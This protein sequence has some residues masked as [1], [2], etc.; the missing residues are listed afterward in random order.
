MSCCYIFF[1]FFK[2][3]EWLKDIKRD[4]SHIQGKEELKILKTYVA[5]GNHYLNIYL[6]KK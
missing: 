5:I 1:G 6:S 2:I 3:E 4:W